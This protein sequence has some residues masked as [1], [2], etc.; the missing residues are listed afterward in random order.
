MPFE[1]GVFG[2]SSSSSLSATAAYSRPQRIHEG[3]QIDPSGRMFLNFLEAAFKFHPVN[4]SVESLRALPLRTLQTVL[5]PSELCEKRQLKISRG[6]GRSS[7][8]LALLGT[9]S[10]TIRDSLRRRF[11]GWNLTENEQ[12]RPRFESSRI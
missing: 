7:R 10:K 5:P 3:N 8:V 11:R 1:V 4:D 9:S 12:M 2:R 6:S